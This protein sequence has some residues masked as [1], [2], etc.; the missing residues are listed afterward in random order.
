MRAFLERHPEFE[1]DENVNYLPEVLRPHA[2]SGM[3]SILPNRDGMEGFFI[4]RMRRRED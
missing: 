2:E 4:A 1:M 3:I